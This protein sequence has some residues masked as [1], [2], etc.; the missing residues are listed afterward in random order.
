M[1]SET[2]RSS[3]TLSRLLFACLGLVLAPI[4]W[5]HTGGGEAGGFIAGFSHPL[6][7]YDHLLA[8]LAV[9]IW[10]AFLGAP[11]IWVLPVAF[12]LVMAVGA[13]FGIAGVPLP[14][15]EW[16]IALSVIALGAA[17]LMAARPPIAA[18]AALVAAFAIFHGYAHG[19][20]L[21]GGASPVAFAAGFV[22][23]TG[24]IH[25]AGIAI[26]LL[27]RVPYG[28][29]ILRTGGALIA[30]AGCYFGMQLIA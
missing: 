14:G 30:L 6:F 22:L 28:T 2:A 24:S 26:G 1:P 3:M 29:A 27:V 10:G 4:A 15:V 23:A 7:G 13:V 25:V 12:P 19:Q 16:G 21:P 5:A 18:A 17:I 9:G 8:M 20:E 11:A